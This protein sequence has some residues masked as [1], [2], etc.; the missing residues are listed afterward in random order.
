MND[1]KFISNSHFMLSDNFLQLVENILIEIVKNQNV[2]IYIGSPREDIREHYQELTKW[3]D[4]RILVPTL[5][6]FFHGIE[7][8]L[9]ASNYKKN[10]PIK[11]LNHNLEQLFIDF[12]KNYP[13]SRVITDI[14][15]NYIHP[16]GESNILKAFYKS[17][18]ISNSSKFYEV[19]KYPFSKDLQIQVNYGKLNHLYNE[20]ISFFQQFIIDIQTIRNETKKL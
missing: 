13:D 2:D 14:L 20:G 15:H 9:K 6:N 4:F 12:K 7:L 17:N 8:L 11:K 16:S 3:S 1:K 18:D 19:F 10:I 5:F